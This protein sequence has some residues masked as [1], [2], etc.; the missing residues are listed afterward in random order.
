VY[1]KLNGIEM[2][3]DGSEQWR[4]LLENLPDKGKGA[5]GVC[6]QGRTFRLWVLFLQVKKHT[7]CQT[8]HNRFQT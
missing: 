5:L 4:D 2:C 1:L 8:Q 7:L 3:C 6:V